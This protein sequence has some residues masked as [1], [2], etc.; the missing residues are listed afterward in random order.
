MYDMTRAD[1]P[2]QEGTA[3]NKANLLTDAVATAFGLDD[4]AAPNDILN[5]LKKA[6]L[7]TG[8]IGKYTRHET[9]VG[10]PEGK[11][12]KLNENGSPVEFY[13]AKQDYEAAL[14]GAGRTLVVR[15][16]CVGTVQW[17]TSGTNAYAEN[18]LDTWLNSEYKGR[19]DAGVQTAIEST[20]FYY[21]PGNGNTTIGVLNRAVFALSYSELGYSHSSANQEGSALGIAEKLVPGKNDSGSTVPEWTRTPAINDTNRAWYI[22]SNGSATSYC[23]VS[24]YVHPAFALPETFSYVWYSDDEGNIY[25]EQEYES[26]LTDVLGNK[27]NSGAQAVSGSYVGTGTTGAGNPCTLSFGFTPKLV[28]IMGGNGDSGAQYFCIFVNPLTVAGGLK[29]RTPGFMTITQ[30]VTWSGDSMSWYVLSADTTSGSY[31]LNDGG[32]YQLNYSG[33]VYDYVAIG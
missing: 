28:V 4:A 19:L 18:Y 32:L 5:I 11:T 3:L 12:I 6:T 23:H 21:T 26:Y 20:K 14:N 8:Q 25:T 9:L 16:R 29:F 7:Y 24:N 33:W 27:I 1:Q 15:T 22:D 17:S 10:Y 30:K 2:Q 13:V 31:D